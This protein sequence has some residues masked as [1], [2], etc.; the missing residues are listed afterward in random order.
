MK[1]IKLKEM[2]S[3][4]YLQAHLQFA[5]ANAEGKNCK[6]ACKFHPMKNWF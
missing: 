4:R 5:Q 2:N 6:R 1:E 3:Q